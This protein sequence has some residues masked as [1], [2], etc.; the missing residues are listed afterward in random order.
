MAGEAKARKLSDVRTLKEAHE[1]V[2]RLRPKQNAPLSEWL[3]FRQTSAALYTQV[4]DVDRFHHHEA[5][6][7]AQREQDTADEIAAQIRA[8]KPR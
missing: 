1:A 8:T 5:Q 4:A 2:Q 6:Y 3:V 7:W